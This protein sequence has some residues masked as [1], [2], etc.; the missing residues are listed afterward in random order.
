MS[1]SVHTPFPSL[2]QAHTASIAL[3]SSIDHHA[4]TDWLRAEQI[5][6]IKQIRLGTGHCTLGQGTQM[7]TGLSS[8]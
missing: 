8:P 3:S 5:K 2:A 1:A 6:G 7:S 4:V